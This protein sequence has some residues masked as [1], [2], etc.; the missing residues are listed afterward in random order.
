MKTALILHW[1]WWNSDENWLPWLKD[2][3]QFKVDEVFVPNLPNT[4]SPVLEEQEEYIDIYAS[5]FNDEWYII[6]HSLWCQLAMKFI[7]ENDIKNSITILVAP[8]YP[9]LSSEL[10]KDILDDNYDILEKYYDMEINFDKINKLWNKF[11]VFLSDNDP[12]I[13]MEN[14]KKYYSQLGN[15]EFKE[16]KNKGHFNQAAWILEL[17]EI[18]DYIK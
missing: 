18:L 12:Y 2:K 3:I 6:S 1:W 4:N 17:E 14:A 16:F 13:N 11:I 15:I 9:W 5:D 8:S 10:W 7:D